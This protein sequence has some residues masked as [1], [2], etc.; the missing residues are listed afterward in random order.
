[1]SFLS[2]TPG[3]CPERLLQQAKALPKVTTAVANAVNEVTLESV[4]LAVDEGIIE[5]ILVGD[6]TQMQAAADAIGWDISGYRCE[7]A[8]DEVSA[9][10][11]ACQLVADGE[12]GSLMKGH[13]HTDN[14]LRAVIGKLRTGKKLSHVFHMTVPGSD[15]PLLITDAVI[16][17]APGVV[18][19][20]HII[21]NAV[22]LAHAL[23]NEN[24]KVALI[25]GTEVKT[26]AMP[27]SVEADEIKK[28]AQIGALSGA[29]IDGPLALDGALSEEAAKIKGIKSEVAGK[30]DIL[31]MPNLEA[32]N[33]LFKQM[34]YCMSAT[35][36]GV[37]LGARVPVIL[38][39]RADP[40]AA[41][42]AS[43]ALAAVYAAA[44]K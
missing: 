41:R 23:G 16:N 12:A 3:V 7:Q 30:A 44:Q 21:K 25:S 29:V 8:D 5:P 6:L 31:L 22:D 38:T 28:L 26:K 32:G 9:S 17:V 40:P 18:D 13:V 27:S 35:A 39:S 33:I 19:K 34:V 11:V 15:D 20:L 14:L 37:V 4:R 2:S 10:M 43:C 24:P 42:L 1:M 36:A